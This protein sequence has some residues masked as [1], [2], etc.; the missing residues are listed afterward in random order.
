L[1]KTG[2]QHSGTEGLEGFLKTLRETYGLGNGYAQ[3]L[4]T[5]LKAQLEY[6]TERSLLDGMGR[7]ILETLNTRAAQ[8][9]L[10]LSDSGELQDSLLSGAKKASPKRKGQATSAKKYSQLPTDLE[11]DLGA[12]DRFFHYYHEQREKLNLRYAAALEVARSFEAWR[13]RV[14]T[15]LLPSA[16]F[17][18]LQRE[19]SAQTAYILLVRM[20]LVRIVEDKGLIPRIFTNGGLALWFNQ[21]EPRYL[22]YAQGRSSEFLLDM[23]YASAQH[24]YAHF[25]SGI[26]LFDWYSPDRNLVIRILYRLAGYDLATINH[27]IIGHLYGRYVADEHKHESG[28]YY[29]PPEVVE[30]ILDRLGFSGTSLIEGKKLLDPACGSGTFLVSASRRVVQ[31]YKDFYQNNIPP[32]K[33]QELVDTFINFIYGLDLNP[34][35]CYLAETNLLIQVLD[36][37]KIAYDAGQDVHIDRFHIYNTDTLR[38]AQKT[39]EILAKS[40]AGGLSGFGG[41]EDLPVEEQI[42]AKLGELKDGF[43]FV[44]AN[45]PYVRADEGYEGLLAYRFD[46]KENHPIESVRSVLQLRWD[47]F[48]L[49]RPELF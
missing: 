29:T 41:A 44:V 2:N 19:F 30:Y 22:K 27:D 1:G 4:E 40:A 9:P 20:L 42:K 33:V 35:A 26:R 49:S 24:I 45:P 36:L 46:L 5:R 12:F 14:A 34:F 7:E 23:A 37:L 48:V 21:V 47:L 31:A 16:E 25:Y 13:D 11:N 15:L 18:R 17:E 38:Y 28:M 43:D 8:A 6:H 39:R 3:T 10:K 32:D